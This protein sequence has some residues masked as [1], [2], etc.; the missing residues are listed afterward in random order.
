MES[1]QPQVSQF[2]PIVQQ[3][4]FAL[5]FK[6]TS[7]QLLVQIHQCICLIQDLQDLAYLHQLEQQSLQI[8]QLQIALQ[9]NGINKET[10]YAPLVQQDHIALVV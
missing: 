8:Q 6:S 9:D 1:T 7:I 4:A 5:I 2:V 10:L 3:E